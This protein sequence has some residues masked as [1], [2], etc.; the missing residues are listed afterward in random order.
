MKQTEGAFTKIPN[1]ILDDTTLNVYERAILIHVAR[2]T[3]GYGKKS[4]GISLSQFGKATGISKD[5]AIR[6]IADLNIKKQLKVTKQTSANGGKS[7]NRYSLT[8]VL[9]KD[10]LVADKDNP[11]TSQRQGLVADKDI[12]KK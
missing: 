12:Q 8:L 3:I 1:I 9:H 6:T 10:Y 7:Y 4:D 2:Q 5:K 11:S